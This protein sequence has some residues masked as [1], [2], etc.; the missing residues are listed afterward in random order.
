MKKEI[1]K[2]KSER[3]MFKKKLIGLAE[4][5]NASREKMH[6]IQN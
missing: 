1:E 4:K 6:S 3:D 5:Q 2:T